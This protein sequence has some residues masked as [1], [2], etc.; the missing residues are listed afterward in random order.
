[1]LQFVDS[2]CHL[3]LLD[4]SEWGDEGLKGVIR[5]AQE[6]QVTHFLCVSVDD[7]KHAVLQSI[8]EQFESVYFSVGLHPNEAPKRTM[9]A[10]MLVQHANHPKLVAIGETGLDYFRSEGDLSWQKKR[11]AA[12]IE[13]AHQSKKPLIIHTRQAKS[14]TLSIMASE[15][16]RDVGGVLHCFTED[17]EMAKKALDMGFYISFSG[18]LTFKN[19]AQIQEVAK[20][21]PLDRILIETDSPYL[22]PVP[23]RGKPNYPVYVRHVAE[24]LAAL[25]QNSLQEISQ[26]TTQ[27]F[28]DLFK[29][30]R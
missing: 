23:Y 24:F 14:D 3:D 18:I 11:F 7:T 4:L 2:H 30:K 5:T 17:W 13:A 28:F 26:V 16:A 19:A 22:T 25:R 29:I 9:T 6:K 20:K 8:A 1:M 12:H 15:E 21:M 27:N 10:Q